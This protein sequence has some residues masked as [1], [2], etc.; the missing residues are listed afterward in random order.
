MVASGWQV[1]RCRSNA[2]L[3]KAVIEGLGLVCIIGSLRASPMIVVLL[4]VEV[5]IGLISRSS[6]SRTCV[7]IGYSIRIVIGLFLIGLLIPT[8]PA[9]TS[10]LLET[11]VMLSARAAGAFR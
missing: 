10:S 7:V 4:I 1:G 11:V 5:V 2:S 3:V 9:V 8:V 6:P